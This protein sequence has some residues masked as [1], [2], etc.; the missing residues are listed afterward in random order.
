[1][2]VS[3]L[4][5]PKSGKTTTAAMLFAQLKTAGF[6]CEFITEQARFYIASKRI[7]EH[8]GPVTLSDEDQV[9]IAT[10]QLE[11]ENLML[12]ACSKE[13]VIVT[14]SS[15]LNAL[16]YLYDHRLFEKLQP[17]IL[18][19]S[20]VYFYAQPVSWL[21]E[22]QDNNR[23]HSK[24]ESM[25]I[26]SLIPQVLFPIVGKTHTLVGIPEERSKI[27]YQTVLHYLTGM[28]FQYNDNNR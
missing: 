12:K 10:K 9:A 3:F 2:I 11:I 14:D 22:L 19:R 23:V 8:G 1:M 7:Q 18:K 28:E 17:E 15:P 24:E 21:N 16:L 5:S 25:V 27:A 13:T 6:N 26:D 4:G 20:T